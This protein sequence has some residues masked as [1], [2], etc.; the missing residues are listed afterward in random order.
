[1]GLESQTLLKQM[2]TAPGRL[3]SNKC[4]EKRNREGAWGAGDE[5]WGAWTGRTFT[6]E[7]CLDMPWITG[8]PGILETDP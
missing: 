4:Y 3:E 6:L 8:P 1:M 2:N 5:G 7:G